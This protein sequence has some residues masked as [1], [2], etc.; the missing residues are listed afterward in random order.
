MAAR[1]LRDHEFSSHAIQALEARYLRR[2]GERRIIET[3]HDLFTRVA[4]AI[5]D[6]ERL[7][8]K[9]RQASHWQ[10]EFLRLLISLD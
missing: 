8:Q 2:D 3:P 4:T 10:D 9:P 1:M 7:M 6:A 5:A